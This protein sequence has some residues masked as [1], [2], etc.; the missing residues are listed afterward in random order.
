MVFVAEKILFQI[1]GEENIKNEQPYHILKYKNKWIVTGSLPK[2]CV[3]GVFEI[4]INADNSQIEAV[5][6][7][8]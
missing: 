4:V 6:H 1:Y 7:G 8:E 5:I 2:G 3:G